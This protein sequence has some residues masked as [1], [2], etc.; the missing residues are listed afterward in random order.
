MATFGTPLPRIE[1]SIDKVPVTPMTAVEIADLK[2]RV[3]AVR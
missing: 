1:I 2:L 3:N